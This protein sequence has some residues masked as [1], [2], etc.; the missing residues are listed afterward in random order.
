MILNITRDGFHFTVGNKAALNAKRLTDANGRKEHIALPHQFFRALGIQNDTGLHS[1][2]Y[3]ERDP[4]GNICFHQTGDHIRRGP[5]GCNN[6][7]HSGGTAHLGNTADR[8]FHFLRCNQHQVGQLIDD[9]N[10]LGK[11]LA[12]LFCHHNAVVGLQIPDALV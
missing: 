10:Y 11:L 6:Q 5:L 4:G 8:V 2:S 9:D 12:A 1:G 3:R 7:M